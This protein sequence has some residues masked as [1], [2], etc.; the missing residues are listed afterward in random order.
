MGK[1]LN[2]TDS[3]ILRHGVENYIRAMSPI[4]RHCYI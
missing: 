3:F 4:G 2:D 1:K